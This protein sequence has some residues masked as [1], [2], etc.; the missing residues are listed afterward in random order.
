MTRY[1]AYVGAGPAWE[2]TMTR[3]PAY[4]HGC[5]TPGPRE[6]TMTRYPAYVRRST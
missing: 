1:P 3:H 5:L 4:V 6:S 2:L